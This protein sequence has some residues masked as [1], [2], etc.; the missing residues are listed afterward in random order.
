MGNR[1]FVLGGVGLILVV[2]LLSSLPFFCIGAWEGWQVWQ[3]NQTFETVEG[4][5]IDNVLISSPDPDDFT[6]ESSSYHP[7]VR[8]RTVDG[9]TSSFTEGVGTYPAKYELG[10][11][12]TVLYDPANPSDAQIRSWEM[13]FPPI[14]FM[15][16]GVLPAGIGGGIM[17]LIRVLGRKQARQAGR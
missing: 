8:F 15:V 3:N 14:L 2:L 11:K 10:D 12:V 13:W 5:V 16:I 7:V 6:R 17:L 9:G 4:E 1:K